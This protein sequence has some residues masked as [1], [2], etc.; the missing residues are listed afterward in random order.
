L[1]LEDTHQGVDIRRFTVRH[2]LFS[3]VAYPGLRRLLAL[4]SRIPFVPVGLLL[5]ISR[6]TPW[7]PELWKWTKETNQRYDIVAGMTIGFEPVMAAGQ[8]YA[9]RVG[10]P[11]VCY[12][13][14]H[15]GAGPTPGADPV[16]RYYTLRHQT[17]V[18]LKSDMVIAQTPTEQNYYEERGLSGENF[19][20]G[21]PGVNP[22]EVL[23]GEGAN[24]AERFGI[25]NPLILFIG[26]LSRDKGAFDTL[27]AGLLLRRQGYD[28]DL[29]FIG[30]ISSSFQDR[31]DRLSDSERNFIRLLGPVD[32][33]IKRDALAAASALSMPSRTDS[34]GITYLEAWLYGVPVIAART[35]G[36]TDVVDHGTD[37][38]VV[39]F[40]DVNALTGALGIILDNPNEAKKMGERGRAKVYQTH[41]WETKLRAV[42]DVYQRL[43]SEKAE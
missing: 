24:F 11:F 42:E 33:S 2:L 17:A 27:E 21:G 38:L 6:Y 43:I 28:V 13:L 32:D 36:V 39:P 40:G 3:R 41:L 14:T 15:F 9:R 35:W 8:A 19:L 23:G 16:S 34:F 4:L 30:T 22:S 7:V 29:A 26:Y 5:R 20:I 18:V 1:D 10:A 25:E 12:P 37:G 31:F